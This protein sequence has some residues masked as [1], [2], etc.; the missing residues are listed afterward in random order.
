M[1]MTL[2]STQQRL[3]NPLNFN[4][5]APA[6]TPA[7]SNPWSSSQSQGGG[8]S[9]AMYVGNP[10]P[11]PP[12]QLNPSMMPG[13]PHDGRPGNTSGASLP[14]YPSMPIPTTS[15]GKC[16][17]HETTALCE[18]NPLTGLYRSDGYE[19]H[20]THFGLCRCIVRYFSLTSA[21]VCPCSSW[22]L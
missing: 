11:P 18:L 2:D 19:P 10:P 12:P 15:A 16:L 13:K 20:A 14:S 3:G 21:R 6:Q 1:T 17:V 9:S 4:Y 22:L 8:R 5:S 7:F